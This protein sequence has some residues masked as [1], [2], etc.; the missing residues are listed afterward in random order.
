MTYAAGAN[1]LGGTS[2]LLDSVRT[3]P[4]RQL[5]ELRAIPVL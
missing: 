1:T 5:T 3:H 2:P 4:A